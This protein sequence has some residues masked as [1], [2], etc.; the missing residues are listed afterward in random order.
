MYRWLKSHPEIFVPAKEIHFFGKDLDHRRPE[1]SAERYQGLFADA[2]PAHKA[3]GDVAVWYLM[4]ETAAEEIHAFRPDARIIIMLRQPD[5]MLHS[6]HS[7]LLY[8]GEEDIEDFAEALAAESDRARGQR[9]P[10]ST[11]AGLEAPPSECLQY[12]RVVSFAEQVRRYRDRFEHVHVVLH[13]DIRADAGTAYRGVLDFLGVDTEF[14]PD[15]SVVNPNTRVKSQ[16]A[17]KL[18]QGTRFGPIRSMVPG[19]VRA[20][21]RKVFE[22]LQSMNT[23]TVPRP[24]LEPDIA[25]RL[26]EQMAPDVRQLA[27]LIGRDLSGWLD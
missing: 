17:R 24:P 27:Q 4:S 12:T 13:S 19:S 8:S 23:E 20:V 25:G 5:Q 14:E 18:I 3:V 1:V 2:G 7:Q 9:I 15:F 10:V 11:H 16:A 22:G 26:R 21:G 6:L